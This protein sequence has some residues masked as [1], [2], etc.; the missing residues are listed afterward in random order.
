[1]E[2]KPYILFVDDDPI[3][4]GLFIQEFKTQFGNTFTYEKAHNPLE[5]EE[6]IDEEYQG[7]GV[8][9][10]LIISDWSMP[11][12]SGSDFLAEL[13]AL[14]PEVPLILCS[15]LADKAIIDDIEKHAKL[16]CTLS[17]PWDGKQGILQ[18]KQVLQS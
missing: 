14:Y 3:V 13:Y 10:A 17:K 9:P 4:I 11:H 5:A 15:G 12:K 2:P 18:I 1:M 6:I 16:L 8:L 7:R